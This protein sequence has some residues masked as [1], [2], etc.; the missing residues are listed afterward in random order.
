MKPFQDQDIR[1]IYLQ[2]GELFIDSSPAV[3]QTVLGSC[4]SV[5][6]HC[7]R[8]GFGGICHAL[9]P[10]GN[11]NQPG[12]YVD[13]V[14]ELLLTEMLQRGARHEWLEVKLFGG[15]KVLGNAAGER[16]TVGEQNVARARALLQRLKLQLS[17]DD[18]GGRR[19]RRLF[20]NSGT[21]EVFIRKVRKNSATIEIT[22]E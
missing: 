13:R 8:G 15:G 2:P 6:M 18:T 11:D 10:S 19:G 9:L 17:A 14:V 16:Q 4:V 20:F 21:G 5:T 3:V 7:P 22:W 1:Q 12:R